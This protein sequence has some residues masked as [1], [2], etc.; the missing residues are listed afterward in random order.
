MVG[1]TW[2]ELFALSFVLK[3]ASLED[4]LTSAAENYTS[5]KD[6][7]SKE[8]AIICQTAIETIL[9]QH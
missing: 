7:Y 2:D 6:D 9:N 3:T 8:K 1:L 4:L 5:K